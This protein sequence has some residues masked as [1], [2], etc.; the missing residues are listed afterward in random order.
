MVFPERPDFADVAELNT[1]D[2][3]FYAVPLTDESVAEALW[4]VDRYPALR[5]QWISQPL[6][7]TVSFG[8]VHS[9]TRDP[10]TFDAR[11]MAAYLDYRARNG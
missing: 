10:D 9:P 11:Q 7:S 2:S 8:V 3:G 6:W 1:R 4:E 5:S